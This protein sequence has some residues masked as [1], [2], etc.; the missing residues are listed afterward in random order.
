M[1]NTIDCIFIKDPHLLLGFPTPSNRQETFFEEIQKK[2]DFIADYC[3]KRNIT[4]VI[5]TGDLFDKMQMSQ[6][7]WKAVLQNIEFIKDFNKKSGA[8]LYSIRGNH[9]EFNGKNTND[10]TVF[11]IL[12]ELGLIHYFGNEN[13][14]NFISL[15]L[16][17]KTIKIHG[18][19]WDPS[20]ANLFKNIKEYEFNGDY[21]V[22][23]LH[24]AVVDV[25]SG[26]EN[27]ECVGYDTLVKTNSKVNMWVL[28]HY[29]KG[30]PVSY[31][32]DKY[33]INPWNLT[34][35]SR[36]DYVLNNEH[37]P[38][39]VHTSFSL[40]KD[41]SIQVKCET[42]KIPVLSFEESFKADTKGLDD[43]LLDNFKFFT[44][45]EEKIEAN[46][47]EYEKLNELKENGKINNEVYLIIKDVLS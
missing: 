24:T 33:F 45:I 34:R 47:D 4:Y 19:D 10:K 46:F 43:L 41:R 11:G 22:S 13:E 38:E 6:W 7:S 26:K 30:Y 21:N 17:D 27:F 8:N 14:Q 32:K 2:W 40:N 12:V 1:P 31:Y 5:I 25:Q 16:E 20:N 29:H 39:F 28:G 23:V 18:F 44:K 42:I 15:P 37:T 35:L 36:V 9:D 3:K